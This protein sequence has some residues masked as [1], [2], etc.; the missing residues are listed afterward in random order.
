MIEVG[1]PYSTATTVY[2]ATGAPADAGAV[3][4]TVTAPDGTV[5]VLPV[6][7]ES[8][9]RYRTGLIVSLP[10]TWQVRWRA[11]GIN[12]CVDDSTFHVR[13][14]AAVPVISLVDAKAHLNITGNDSDDELVR[15]IDVASASGEAWTGRV[16]G[17]RTC[18]D[19]LSGS[20]S[21]LA[22]K[23][24]PVLSV[25]SVTENGAVVPADGWTLTSP[26]GGVLTRVNGW[27]AR[28]WASGAGNVTVIYQAGYV[29]QPPT[30]VQGALE[31]VRHLW[32][33][34][35]GSIR[36]RGTTDPGM[37]ATFSVPLRVQELWNSNL[38]G[39]V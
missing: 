28:P 38:M 6:L 37:L 13:D 30:D 17:R 27:T 16:F 1:D 18:V 7:H 14:P 25:A 12:E 15:T 32:Q 39:S 23:S 29:V 4:C 21:Y 35:R 36:A 34:Q 19:V 33:S 20:G 2:D 31:M 10:G 11:T 3:T 24:C 5:T 26:E 22:L 8:P 9:G